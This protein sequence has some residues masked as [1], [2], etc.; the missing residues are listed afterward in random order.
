MAS[1]VATYAA[2]ATVSLT[3]GYWVGTRWAMRTLSSDETPKNVGDITKPT[4]D[5][6]PGA[7]SDSSSSEEPTGEDLAS[8]KAGLFEDCKLALVVRVDLGMSSG[9]IAAQCSHA[10]LACYKAL[11]KSNPALL[12]RWERTGQSKVAL[13]ADSDEDLETM[14]A[15]ARSLNLCARAIHDAGRTQIAAG[16]RTVLGIGPGPARL[17]NQVTGK[18]RLL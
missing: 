6:E 5:S 17:V 4:G 2:L 13:R 15:M 9:K 18:L 3:I 7:D 12:R 8:V 14:E 1:P 11:G 16:S 10:T